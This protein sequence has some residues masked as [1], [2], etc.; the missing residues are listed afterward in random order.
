M[1][2]RKKPVLKDIHDGQFQYLDRWVDKS[3]FR[4]FVYNKAGQEK[5]AS[6]YDQFESLTASGLWFASKPDVS[7]E[8]KPKNVLLAN[9]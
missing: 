5:L 1:D 6:S 7:K 8:R 9:S 4:A 2:Q 3:T